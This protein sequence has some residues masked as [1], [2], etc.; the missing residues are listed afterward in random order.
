MQAGGSDMAQTTPP[1]RYCKVD[2]PSVSIASACSISAAA[3]T[4]VPVHRRV[5]LGVTG[6]RV[7]FKQVRG[8]HDLSALA[9][10]ALRNIDLAP[11][12]LQWMFTAWMQ[13]FDGRDAGLAQRLHATLTRAHRHSVHMHRARATL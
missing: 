4:N 10:A 9:E 13:S 6:L 5:D 1:G 7:L 2:C 8:L 12:D 3:S 11:R